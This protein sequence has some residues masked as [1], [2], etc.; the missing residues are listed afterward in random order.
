MIQITCIENFVAKDYSHYSCFV[1][2]PLEVGQGITLGSALRRTLLSDLTGYGIQGIR[3]ND[4]KDE[5]S[6]LP[7]TREDILD[8]IFNMK[9]ILFR[10][11]I[12]INETTKSLKKAIIPGFLAVTGPKIVTAGMLKLPKN[13]FTI[14]NPYQYICTLTK[15]SDFFC[16]VEIALG[17]TYQ[18]AEDFAL[19]HADE[20][21]LPGKPRTLFVDTYYGP[22]QNVT[23]KVKLTY[24]SQ[25]NLKEALHIEIKTNGTKTPKRCLYEAIKSLIDLLYPLLGCS[26][27]LNFSS[28]LSQ[29][30]EKEE[31]KNSLFANDLAK[32]LEKDQMNKIQS[33]SLLENFQKD[34]DEKK[35]DSIFFE[36]KKNKST[37][38]K[39]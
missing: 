33:S 32:N 37:Q 9:E 18:D 22:I 34:K 10:E 5:Y 28:K 24:D 21:F 14:L 13:T 8:I 23:F 12:L 20:I 31:I 16:E 11:S 25:G 26:T 17:K 29:S 3:I 15:K 30:L 36:K 35:I 19:E 38:K 1:L 4:I 6:A 27:F 7:S 2:E 39:N